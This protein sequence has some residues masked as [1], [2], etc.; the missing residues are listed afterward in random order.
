MVL[1]DIVTVGTLALLEGLLSADNA[2][3]LAIQVRHLPTVQRAQ[4]LRYGLL[5]AF[6]FRFLC[7]LAASTLI[8]AWYFKATG[9]AYLLY[10]GVAHLLLSHAAHDAEKKAAAHAS[11]WKTVLLVELT[12]LAFSVDSILAAVAMSDKLWV[13]YCGGIAGIVAMRFVANAFITLMDKHPGLTTGAYLLVTW[14]GCKLAIG[15]AGMA[16]H[17]SWH[18]PEWIFWLGMG[19][20]FFGS[21]LW[22][23]QRPSRP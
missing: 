4:A 21:L 8:H 6:V 16:M 17:Q 12:D 7:L 5:G 1:H 10:I 18:L 14:I 2:L 13:I 15:A 11:F 3:V 9:A 19:A 23:P 20:L 22:K